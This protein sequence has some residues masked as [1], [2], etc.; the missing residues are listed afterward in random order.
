[1]TVN[2]HQFI[3]WF[4]AQLSAKEPGAI[5][6]IFLPLCFWTTTTGYLRENY[7]ISCIRR[8]T[9]LTSA[10]TA[11]TTATRHR[12]ARWVPTK[13]RGRPRKT[14]RNRR[15]R[16]PPIRMIRFTH[17]KVSTNDQLRPPV[18]RPGYPLIRVVSAIFPLCPPSQ[19][20]NLMSPFIFA[21]VVKGTPA[22]RYR[23]KRG[24]CRSSCLVGRRSAGKIP[25]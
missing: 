18:L 10:F 8:Q 12:K 5:S 21:H 9:Y 24:S 19:H 3:H 15:D 23:S 4:Q 20:V 14:R 17:F 22:G 7:T 11:S 25:R 13:T 16:Y 1:M 2:G 6:L